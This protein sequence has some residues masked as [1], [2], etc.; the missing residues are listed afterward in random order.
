MPP[1]ATAAI[2]AASAIVTPLRYLS[3]RRLDRNGRF[4]RLVGGLERNRFE[5]LR[6]LEQAGHK[7]DRRGGDA[8]HVVAAARHRVARIGLG[9]FGDGRVVIL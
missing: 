7:G 3:G 4:H 5:N 9:D 6:H 8:R 1:T 2:N